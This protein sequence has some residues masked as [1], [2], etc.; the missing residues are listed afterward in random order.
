MKPSRLPACCTL[1]VAI[2]GFACAPATGLRRD[3]AAA[4]AAVAPGAPRA[5]AGEDV[6]SLHYSRGRHLYQPLL[7]ATADPSVPLV[8]SKFKV[9]DALLD[10]RWGSPWQS[11]VPIPTIV[12]EG[13]DAWAHTATRSAV[14]AIA[15]SAT[16]VIDTHGLPVLRTRWVGALSGSENSVA[17]A[18]LFRTLLEECRK[19][20]EEL[21]A[22]V[23][24]VRAG[25]IDARP[26]GFTS[27]VESAT[28][29]LAV[30]VVASTTVPVSFVR[31][32]LEPGVLAAGYETLRA[33]L[34]E[35]DIGAAAETNRAKIM[36]HAQRPKG[37]L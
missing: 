33:A 9:N 24:K 10:A 22:A 14:T 32:D 5:T 34:V 23:R 11:K 13:L 36:L 19:A 8:A 26:A 17:E 37:G 16:T 12:I 29:S 35:S 15:A 1:A 4:E 2:L 21:D 25:A 7:P 6:E 30:R 31:P 28:T 3:V 18:D 20:A 27:A